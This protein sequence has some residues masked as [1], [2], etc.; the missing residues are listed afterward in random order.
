MTMRTFSSGATRDN[1]DDKLDY[2]GFICPIALETYAEYLHKHRIQS[3][4]KKRDSD[5]WQ[6]GIPIKECVKSLLRHTV[7]L[8]KI[9]R[10]HIAFDRKDG[11][12]INMSEAACAIVFN[13]FAILHELAALPCTIP[14]AP[15]QYG[16]EMADQGSHDTSC[17]CCI[18]ED[19]RAA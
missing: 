5:S 6:K 12:E 10:G 11:H 2:E 18:R 13:A 9:N 14:P 1:S 4:G 3:D 8:W 15:C 7:D 16:D 19:K 17:H